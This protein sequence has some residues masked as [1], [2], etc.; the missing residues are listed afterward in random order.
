MP[1]VRTQ[2]PQH[3]ENTDTSDAWLMVLHMVTPILAQGGGGGG[4]GAGAGAVVDGGGGG[5]GSW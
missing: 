5:C 1:S 3:L 2:G 4:G